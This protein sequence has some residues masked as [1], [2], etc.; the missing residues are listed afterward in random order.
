MSNNDLVFGV[1]GGAGVAATNKFNELLEER[2]TSANASRDSHHPV[3]ISYQATQVPSRSMFLEK[4]GK[5]FIPGYIDISEKLE[6]SGST[7]LCM[8][9]NTAHYAINEIQSAVN[10]PFINL[11][12]E[13]VKTVKKDKYATVGIMASNGSVQLKIYD[14]YFQKEYPKVKIIYP[15]PEIQKELTK[16]IVNIKNKNRFKEL[17]DPERPN[18]I[19]KRVCTHLQESGADVVIS[20][21]TDIRVD[22]SGKDCKVRVVDSLE[23]LVEVIFNMHKRS[24]NTI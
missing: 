2:V 17:T 16:G 13:V 23:V 19:F 18:F 8:T 21:C 10:L 20:G 15:S 7:V 3:V 1:I 11:I 5:S 24:L 9:C 6:K 12:R 4:K 22:F 14:K